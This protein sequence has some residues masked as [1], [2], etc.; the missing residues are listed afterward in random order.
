MALAGLASEMKEL[1]EL[2]PSLLTALDPPLGMVE[3]PPSAL[4]RPWQRGRDLLL[5][6]TD[7]VSDARNRYG[8]RFGEE[9]VLDAVRRYRDEAPTV[10][11]EALF[12]ELTE[13]TGDALQRFAR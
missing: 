8:E 5:L 3:T 6:F 12:S 10:I 1:G 2:D 11:I 9:R 4:S 13:H 7:G